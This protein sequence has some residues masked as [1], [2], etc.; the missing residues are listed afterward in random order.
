MK[1]LDLCYLV[2]LVIVILLLAYFIYLIYTDGAVCMKNPISYYENMKN[3][4][5][6]C[7][8]FFP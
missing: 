2:G 7:D 6:Y 3:V 5:C 1:V 4:S 8:N